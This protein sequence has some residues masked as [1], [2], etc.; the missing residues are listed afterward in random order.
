MAKIMHNAAKKFDWVASKLTFE[1]HLR[2][3]VSKTARSPRVVCRA[4]KL[5]D[6]PRVL[7]SCF[8]AYAS[9][10]LEYCALVWI[11]STE[12]HLGL[13][14]SAVRNEGRLCEDELCCLGHRRKASTLCLLYKIYDRG[15]HCMNEYLN[16]CVAARNNRA[17]TALGELSL[18][19]L[20]SR[21]NQFR[22]SFMAVAERLWNLLPPDMFSCG[23]LNT[24]LRA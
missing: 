5:F 21:M 3:I 4:G 12:F 1:T 6:C 17:L 8:N 24:L 16:P 7:K 19:V 9:L 14:D 11:L 2:E 22:L 18:A 15:D 23:T 13:L 10:N 20:R